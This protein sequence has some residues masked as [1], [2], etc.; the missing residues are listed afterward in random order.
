MNHDLK[1][2]D[3]I[4]VDIK[5]LGINGE[6][7]AF[8]KKL[9]VFVENALP[10]ENVL[11]EI[12]SV[13]S[14]YVLAKVIEQ[15]TKSIDRTIPECVYY[16]KCGGCNM[17]H[18]KYQA[19]GK[20]KK[21]MLE[22][23]ISRYSGLNPKSF[24]IKDTVLS[25]NDFGYRMKAT[26]PLRQ[27]EHGVVWGLYHPNSEKFIRTKNCMIHHGLI[28][29]IADDICDIL[30]ELNI[31]AYDLKNKKGQIKYL[32]IRT[33][34]YN[35]DSQVTFIFNELPKNLKELGS[36]TISIDNVISVYYSIN[37]IVDGNEFFGDEIV[38][39][40]GEDYLLEKIGDYKYQLLPNSFFQVNVKQAENL[41]ETVKKLAKLS[42]KENVVD[43]YCGVGAIGIYLAK[44]CKNVYGVEANKNAFK[45]AKDNAE[46][47]GIKNI[48]FLEGDVL[49]SLAYLL[50]DKNEIDILVFDPP[51]TG[52]TEDIIKI[53][54]KASVKKII[55]VSCNPSTLAKDLSLLKEKYQVNQLIPF[56]MFPN[57]SN[58]E[59]VCLLT[60][61][62]GNTKIKNKV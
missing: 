42:H 53:V 32:V 20:Y 15:K 23:A 11:V 10:K 30:N 41:F 57:T 14:K 4:F 34:L 2:G 36:R 46:L 52:L 43:A 47:N 21:E 7:I 44:Y 13:K 54:L 37:D 55:Y 1:I 18:I 19:T 48:K 26:L 49:K 25:E 40:E 9:S 16:T 8:Y 28:N 24:E 58:I 3:Q 56:D 22:E 12:T 29:K 27:G 51:R 33:S 50:K 31:K 62:A 5:R 45:N 35:D 38:K 59:S 60:N 6:G 61:R 39:L 17:S